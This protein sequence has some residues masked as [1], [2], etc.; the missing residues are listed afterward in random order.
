MSIGTPESET[1]VA[2]GALDEATEDF[3]LG[4]DL[5]EDV[6]DQDPASDTDNTQTAD[7]PDDQ[8][9]DGS[10]T[11]DPSSLDANM[12]LRAD[13]RTLPPEWQ[14]AQSFMR[15]K[16]GEA[17]RRVAELESQMAALRNQPGNGQA[18]I[19]G[20][21]GKAVRSAIDGTDPEDQFADLKAQ[22]RANPNYNP[23][24]ENSVDMVGEI[25]NRAIGD[26]LTAQ[27]NFQAQVTQAISG[28]VKMLQGQ[29]GA[30]L[31]SEADTLRQTYGTEQVDGFYRDNAASINN[32]MKVIN[33][34][35]R[36]PF[37]LTEAFELLSGLSA[38]KA[39]AAK[40][41]DRNARNT[42]KKRVSG[43]PSPS[44]NDNGAPLS[45]DDLLAQVEGLGFGSVD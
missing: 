43:S 38:Q 12:L 35:T 21:V 8:G 28:I 11:I 6:V 20:A 25:V 3:E 39:T 31:Q 24:D 40:A 44:G 17:D 29:Q 15:S 7:L 10:E 16:Q 30:S 37:T 34:K 13:P 23:G 27:E 42:A 14:R 36:Q 19:A 33:P 5:F 18:D 26:K 22:I 1:D 41:K 9:D 2:D 4:A 32:Q 45:D